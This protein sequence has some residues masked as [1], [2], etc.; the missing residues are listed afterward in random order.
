MFAWRVLPLI[1][2]LRFVVLQAGSFRMIS[3]LWLSRQLELPTPMFVE[4]VMP[5]DTQ[6]RLKFEHRFHPFRQ[7]I[8][9]KP[10]EYAQFVNDSTIP[11]NTPPV[12][13]FK[14]AV[15]CFKRCQVNVDKLRTLAKASPGPGADAG[16][17]AAAA[18]LVGTCEKWKEVR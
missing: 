16:G 10:L 6:Q 18:A 11:P 8:Q 17:I 5:L 2:T 9:P 4:K 3:G 7:L 12:A 14:Q 1:M 15:E 13:I